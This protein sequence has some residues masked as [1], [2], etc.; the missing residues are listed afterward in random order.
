[1]AGH[2]SCMSHLESPIVRSA[3]SSA[4]T[5]GR[6][7][8][9]MPAECHN[10]TSFCP[11][12]GL[13]N[14]GRAWT[15][16]NARWRVIHEIKASDCWRLSYV[17]GYPVRWGL[18]LLTWQGSTTIVSQ[19]VCH[20]SFGIGISTWIDQCARWCR[21][22]KERR[23]DGSQ[24]EKKCFEGLHIVSCRLR[25]D[26]CGS[27]TNYLTRRRK[28]NISIR[29]ESSQNCSSLGPTGSWY[30]NLMTIIHPLD[31]RIEFSPRNPI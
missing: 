9:P 12:Y 23:A 11:G 18:I 27:E 25:I 4:S 31:D 22:N 20:E 29:F 28:V 6:K 30:W 10:A 21:L 7:T 2:R 13:L 24:A 17:L 14:I 19:Q 15:V 5:F 3:V 8:Y 26:R 16:G 1:M